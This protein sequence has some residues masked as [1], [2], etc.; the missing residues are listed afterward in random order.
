[1]RVYLCPE[2][3]EKI[4]TSWR[5]FRGHWSTRHKGEE[6]P[7]REE[8][9]QE[10]DREEVTQTKIER[11]QAGG[12]GEERKAR[13]DAESAA[14]VAATGGGIALSD[15]P[16]L[17]ESGLPEE[18]VDRLATI[19]DV[20][21]VDKVVR[22]Q[23]LRIFQLHPGYRENPVNLHY[24]LT[25]RLPRKMHSSAPMMI[26]AYVTQ[27]S[28]YPEGSP[29]GFMPGMG[30]PGA[31]PPFMFGGGFS[32]QYQPPMGYFPPYR[33]SI[34][35]REPAMEEREPRR[36]GE[37]DSSVSSTVALLGALLDV[38][39]KLGGGKSEETSKLSEDLR[40]SYEGLRDT[41]NEMAEVNRAEKEDIRS[42]FE[43]K[44]EAIQGESRKAVEE[45][46]EARHKAEME[47]R[48]AEIARLREER[49]EERSEGLGTLLKE[50]GEGVGVQVEGIRQ[51]LNQ[52]MDRI[53]SIVETAAKVAPPEVSI[54]R[55]GTGKQK[56]V[57][58]ATELMEAETELEQIAQ[59]LGEE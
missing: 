15:V 53:G 37:G 43:S 48:E 24:L 28:T 41:L 23:I 35:G 30:M 6:C 13:M 59:Q 36:R 21:G 38:T 57:A 45:A 40:A 58:D 2:H 5:K 16:R 20:H 34:S 17:G 44:L 9:A 52:G 31:N 14:E 47:S 49:E 54:K 12:A 32:N 4:Y 19:L 46:K 56:T 33:P 11:G 25:A 26:S 22:D 42:S 29:M 8:F 1:M 27:D 51:S 10:M 50:A 7:P 39:Q 3:P 18:P 55:G